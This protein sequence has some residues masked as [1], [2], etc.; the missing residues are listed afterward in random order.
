MTSQSGDHG[1]DLIGFADRTLGERERR[2]VARHLEE[3]LRCAEE[4]RALEAGA[5]AARSL[6]GSLDEAERALVSRTLDRIAVERAAATAVVEDDERGRLGTSGPARLRL[7]AAA[8][9]V[10]GLGWASGWA[11]RVWT[12]G[13]SGAADTRRTD[14]EMVVAPPEPPTHA[15]FLVVSDT[16]GGTMAQRLDA[17]ARWAGE[18]R[19]ADRL[20]MAE[21]LR[22]TA[23]WIDDRETAPGLTPAPPGVIGSSIGFYLLRVPSDDAA[24]EIARASP[25]LGFGG[26]IL[27]RPIYPTARVE[28]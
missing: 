10:L 9:L 21:A 14:A 25:H 28:P 2:R 22:P 15:L 16:L 24:L 4:V 3:C 18:L 12:A 23:Y 27:V 1:F 17:Y 20:A 26:E 6:R 11:S 13:G 8:V 7:V 19:A 5:E